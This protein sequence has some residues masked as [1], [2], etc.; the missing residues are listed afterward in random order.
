MCCANTKNLS[1]GYYTTV[2]QATIDGWFENNDVLNIPN[3]STVKIE[4]CTLRVQLSETVIN[5]KVGGRL[6]LINCV[7][8]VGPTVSGCQPNATFDGIKVNGTPGAPQYSTRPSPFDPSQTSPFTDVSKYTS[9]HGVLIMTGC[10]I[11]KTGTREVG[12]HTISSTNGG[13]VELFDCTFT[14]NR[15][16]IEIK[17]YRHVTGEDL[18]DYNAF[19]IINCTFETTLTA[20]SG[21]LGTRFIYLYGVRKV[22]IEGCHFLNKVAYSTTNNT[23]TTRKVTNG[24]EYFQSDFSLQRSGFDRTLSS[25]DSETD[26]PE[27]AQYSRK[28]NF[29]GLPYAIKIRDQQ[30]FENKPFLIADCEIINCLGGIEIDEGESG[31][32]A[33]NSYTFSDNH[34]YQD[35]L[36]G[37]SRNEIFFISISQSKKIVISENSGEISAATYVIS[38][39]PYDIIAK[40]IDIKPLVGLESTE[41]QINIYRNSDRSFTNYL[42]EN[43][44]GGFKCTA[45]RSTTQTTYGVKFEAGN[46]FNKSIYIAINCNDFDELSNPIDFNLANSR[47]QINTKGTSVG[48]LENNGEKAT[49]NIFNNC[50]TPAITSNSDINYRYLSGVSN[51]DPGTVGS[52][53]TKA[54]ASSFDCAGLPCEESSWGSS[55]DEILAQKYAS[56]LQ[57]Y[58]NP[59]EGAFSLEWKVENKKDLNATYTIVLYN[60]LGQVVYT[61]NA[62]G[63]KAT[64]DLNNQANQIFFG[65]VSGSKGLIGNFKIRVE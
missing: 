9:S 11:K 63:N 10:E 31:T 4:N 54:T 27:Y 50:S 56:G 59:S 42:G 14:N 23:A 39:N 24:I 18:S 57:V 5:V 38:G 34:R 35:F 21:D 44:N 49:M 26:C 52:N 43:V 64:I 61:K 60:S 12:N 8:V 30:G 22:Q 25:L 3:G 37:D 40:F 32:V 53:I 16:C 51:H 47:A 36:L 19:N 48:W 15:N 33:R 1:S 41:E 20:P 65:S 29:E 17:D 45:P 6:V 7:L 28:N 13:C 58:P 62:V 55:M 2:D 46:I